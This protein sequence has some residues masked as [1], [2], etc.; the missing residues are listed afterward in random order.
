MGLTWVG[1]R[2]KIVHPPDV[3]LSE[4]LIVPNLPYA[5]TVPQ[6]P[7]KAGGTKREMGGC[8]TRGPRFSDF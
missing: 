6:T 2:G 7:G 5:V 4:V 8:A 3:V 1:H